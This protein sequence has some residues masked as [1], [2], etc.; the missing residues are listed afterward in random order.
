[1]NIASSHNAYFDQF[2]IKVAYI[3]TLSCFM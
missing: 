3:V 1:M 2:H